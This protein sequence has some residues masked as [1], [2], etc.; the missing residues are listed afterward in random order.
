MLLSL[1]LLAVVPHLYVDKAYA[2]SYIARWKPQR[3]LNTFFSVTGVEA[4][5]RARVHLTDEH[6]VGLLVST[7][8]VA[9]VLH[10]HESSLGIASVLWNSSNA[11]LEDF[12]ALREW[13]AYANPERPMLHGDLL[14]EAVE[15][16]LWAMS[17]YRM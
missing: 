11:C 4:Y 6:C 16:D 8:N 9:Y 15:Q 12:H 17:E 10:K 13:Y 3:V 7:H 1:C 5:V 14:T 2:R